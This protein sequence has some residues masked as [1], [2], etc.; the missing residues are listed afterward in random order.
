MSET[1]TPPGTHDDE[2]D[3]QAPPREGQE[4]NAETSLDEPSDN[5]GGEG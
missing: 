5:S 2:R 1:P 3:P 4:E